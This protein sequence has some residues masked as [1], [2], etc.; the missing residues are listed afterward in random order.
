MVNAEKTART[1]QAI[2]RTRPHGQIDI[3]AHVGRQLGLVQ[4]R[5][6]DGGHFEELRGLMLVGS[7]RRVEDVIEEEVKERGELQVTRSDG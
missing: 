1:Y 6:T 4:G 7:D 5:I 2:H 3:A